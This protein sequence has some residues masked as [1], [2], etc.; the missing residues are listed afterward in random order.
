MRKISVYSGLPLSGNRE[1]SDTKVLYAQQSNRRTVS[2]KITLSDFE[3]KELYINPRLFNYYEHAYHFEL[4]FA[5][6]EEAYY[7]TSSVVN[8]KNWLLH[9]LKMR[10]VIM[11]LC[12]RILIDK[13]IPFG[14]VSNI[15]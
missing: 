9:F 11:F 14:L 15:G 13:N 2:P 12:L 7:K 5:E 6:L 10:K 1:I 4:D 8:S 3:G